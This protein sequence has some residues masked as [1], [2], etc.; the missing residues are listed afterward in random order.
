MLTLLKTWNTLIPAW[1]RRTWRCSRH[2][3]QKIS[4]LFWLNLGWLH[5][6]DSI[7]LI[8]ILILSLV[9][10]TL[11][12]VVLSGN[13]NWITGRKVTERRWS[14]AGLYKRYSGIR[15][16][17]FHCLIFVYFHIGSCFCKIVWE[18]CESEI[19]F[20]KSQRRS[21]TR[22]TVD[23]RNRRRRSI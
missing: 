1:W 22:H 21:Q 12:S 7:L 5:V 3:F 2:L 6:T 10:R 4:H 17:S 20:L 16:F 9:W 14:T 8:G 23:D 13:I 11:L 15:L 19:Y 18:T